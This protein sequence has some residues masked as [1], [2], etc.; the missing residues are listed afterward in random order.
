MREEMEMRKKEKYAKLRM[1]EGMEMRKNH[2]QE[3]LTP[4]VK[5][6]IE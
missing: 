1:R 3:P 2:S 5:E 4:F 6:T